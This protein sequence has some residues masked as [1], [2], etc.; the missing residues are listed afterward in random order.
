[1]LLVVVV[2]LFFIRRKIEKEIK[3]KEIKILRIKRRT[4]VSSKKRGRGNQ[5]ELAL[6]GELSAHYKNGSSQVKIKFTFDV[7][8]ALFTIFGG[9]KLRYI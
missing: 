1:M 8:V 4:R 5:A 6:A 9:L 2:I 3:R 7:L